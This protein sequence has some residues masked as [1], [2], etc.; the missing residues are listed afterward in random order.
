MTPE[1]SATVA[2]IA[3][4][5]TDA[6]QLESQANQD[7]IT[8][9]AVTGGYGVE[10][11]D[12]ASYDDPENPGTPIDAETAEGLFEFAIDAVNGEWIGLAVTLD[13]TLTNVKVNNVALTQSDIDAA[14]ALGY[15]G[16]KTY[17]YFVKYT[18]LADAGVTLV[19][20]T[21]DSSKTAKN[22]TIT[23]G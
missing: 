7:V 11:T 12:T 8:V 18:D 16:G 13:E 21:I 23:Q 20:S 4:V 19:L 22:I 9:S 14:T 15:T 10:V 3:T 5:A 17:I 1:L 2:K 6:N